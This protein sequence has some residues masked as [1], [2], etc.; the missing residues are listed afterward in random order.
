MK[1]LIRM[2]QKKSIKDDGDV[3]LTGIIFY[4]GHQTEEKQVKNC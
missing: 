3:D 2:N 1:D 4:L